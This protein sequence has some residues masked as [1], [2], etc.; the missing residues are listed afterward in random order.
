MRKLLRMKF[1]RAFPCA[2]VL[3]VACGTSQPAAPAAPTS[4][5]SS[6][7]TLRGVV[8]SGADQPLAGARVVALSGSGGEAGN[9]T[10]NADG[11]YAIVGVPANRWG[12]QLVSASKTGYFTDLRYAL[13]SP[14]VQ[15]TQLDLNLEPWRLIAVGDV[16]RGRIGESGCAGLGYGGAPG[17]AMCQRF[18]LRSPVTGQLHVTVSAT[19]FDFDVSIVRPEGAIAAEASSSSSP[20]EFNAP[21]EAGLTYQIQVAGG[22][23]SARVFELAT[24]IR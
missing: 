18:A 2:A 10:T 13:Y 1:T 3:L 17:G 19:D 22:W 7:L 20:L 23:S 12:Y 24:S 9:V 5:S 6:V 16:V 21:V 14:A 8:T 15:D 11:T 4:I